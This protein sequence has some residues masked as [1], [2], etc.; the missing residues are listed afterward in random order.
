MA[1]PM[2]AQNEYTSAPQF[3]TTITD[4]T[5]PVTISTDRHVR[6]NQ[7]TRYDS[8][9]R[10][11]FE[12]LATPDPF[13]RRKD[14][15]GW[16]NGYC[17][18][19]RRA[20]NFSTF[21]F[22]VLDADASVTETGEIEIGAPPAREVHAALV[23]ANLTHHIYTTYSHGSW[24]GS[25]YR[26][27]FPCDAR[28]KA[29]LRSLLMYYHET[30]ISAG[31]PL[32]L[33]RESYTIPNRWHF[34]RIE[35]SVAPFYTATHYGYHITHEGARFLS[36]HYQQ[37]D[38]DDAEA[39]GTAPENRYRHASTTGSK[40]LLDTFCDAFRIEGILAENGY[41]FHGY[42]IMTDRAG[43]E[44][45]AM[46]FK[47]PGSGSGPGVVVFESDGKQRLY[48]HHTN[49]PLAV[50]QAIDAYDVYMTLN[51]IENSQQRDTAMRLLHE[52]E[53]EHMNLTYPSIM[54]SGSKFRFAHMITNDF[55]ALEYKFMSPMDFRMVVRNQPG[56]YQLKIGKDG[57]DIELTSRGEWWEGHPNRILYKNITFTPK[58]MHESFSNTAQYHTSRSGELYFNLFTGW[59]T[60][61]KEG[62]WSLIAWHLRHVICGGDEEHYEYLLDWLAHMVQYPEQKPNV[63]VVLKGKK[64]T[65]KSIVMSAIASSLGPLGTVIS[66]SKH[67]TGAFNQHLR[68]KIFALVE[69]SFFSGSP[70][71][72][73]V[74]KHMIS[75]NQTTYESKGYDPESGHSYLRLTL[76]TN[77]EWAAPASE[78]ERRFFIPTVSN[79]GIERNAE[80]GGLYFSRLSQELGGGG[81][82][83]FYD[84]LT[85][86]MVDPVRV[87]RAPGTKEL[88]RQKLLTLKGTAAWLFDILMVGQFYDRAGLPVALHFSPRYNELRAEDLVESH[89]GYVKNY[90]LSR[91]QLVRLKEYMRELFPSLRTEN[92]P[93][94]LY[95]ILPP[96]EEMRRRFSDHYQVDDPW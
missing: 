52:Y 84:A 53:T 4:P 73:S 45:Q 90:E 61:P 42:T 60:K 12:T 33:S 80:E 56:I 85:K 88:K 49:D 93:D 21:Q 78:D 67:L 30:L 76:V 10:E 64:G 14:G 91:S 38:Q 3:V 89:N 75:D 87:R 40:S 36:R 95:F 34:P 27:V 59:P 31:L 65:G 41:T 2:T 26:I 25:R 39:I 96:L 15:Q 83:A 51:Q 19:K 9:L 24:K 20:T 17:S 79:A 71:E 74:L 66:H 6:D 86:R 23:A 29:E 44:I 8:T 43:R 11:F 37:V 55:G 48:S 18:G 50:G 16:Y 7:P 13:D 77:S 63:A 68:N 46:R 82:S 22:A 81:L 35:S 32:A 94:G 69:E 1:S 47:K 58:P 70:S 92:R 62:D 5:L 28:S 54:V 57:S 72:E